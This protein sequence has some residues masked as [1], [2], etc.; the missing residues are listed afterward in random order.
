MT[1]KQS[2]KSG[3][4]ILKEMKEEMDKSLKGVMPISWK[5]HY[6]LSDNYEYEANAKDSGFT[7]GKK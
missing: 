3:E 2:E 7:F 1:G 6:R 5:G 4:Q